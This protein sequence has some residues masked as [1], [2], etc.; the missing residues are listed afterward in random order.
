MVAEAVLP[1]VVVAGLFY[2]VGV[3]PAA[4]DGSDSSKCQYTDSVSG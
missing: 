4:L 3:V 2:P 1:D